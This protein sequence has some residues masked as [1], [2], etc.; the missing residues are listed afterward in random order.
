[1]VASAGVLLFFSEFV[2]FNPGAASGLVGGIRSG[3]VAVAEWLAVFVG[4][5]SIPAAVFLVA[6]DRFRVGT[7]GGL[8]LAGAL[9]GWGV[10]GVV[11]GQMY[12]ALPFSVSWTALGW[13]VLVDV[14]LGW[15]LLRAVLRRNDLLATG[16]AAAGLGIAWGLWATWPWTE[17]PATPPATFAA[18]AAVGGVVWLVATVALDS[19]GEPRLGAT[20][21]EVGVVGVVAAGTFALGVVPAVPVAVAVLPPLVLVTLV[22]LRRTAPADD[23]EATFVP[24]SGTVEWRQHAVLSL[25]PVVAAATYAGAYAVELALPLVDVVAPLLLVAGFAAYG[26]ALWRAV[27]DR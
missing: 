15:Y 13:H 10:E 9:Y 11:V 17:S 16:L 21:A 5:Y 3:P 23:R 27:G 18:F 7:L 19:V 1:V 12:E 2:F 8:V 14:V 6:L 4:F 26:Y 22:A 20:D 24:P 25:V